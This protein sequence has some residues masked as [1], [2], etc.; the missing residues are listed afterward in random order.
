METCEDGNLDVTD[1]CD[2]VC[3]KSTCGDGVVWRGVEECDDSNSNDADRC[4]TDCS[5][6]YGTDFMLVSAP[7]E[8]SMLG[9]VDSTG[10]VPTIAFRST[11]PTLCRSGHVP[12][13]ASLPW[14]PCPPAD[15]MGIV[16]YKVESTPGRVDGGYSMQVSYTD[17]IGAY[18]VSSN[19]Y[20][21]RSIDGAVRCPDYPDTW[22]TDAQFFA[23]AVQPVDLSA[24]VDMPAWATTTGILE[25]EATLGTSDFQ[26]PV[27]A[28]K[29]TDS[30]FSSLVGYTTENL[31][32]RSFTPHM[33]PSKTKIA[34]SMPV[35]SLRHRIVNNPQ[36]TLI[37]VQRAYES[38]TNRRIDN[39]HQCAMKLDFGDYAQ[40]GAGNDFACDAL[41]MN[42]HGEGFCM[43]VTPDGTP[44]PI[45]FSRQL[46]AKIMSANVS[47]ISKA[48]DRSWSAKL[49]D[50]SY[51]YPDGMIETGAKEGEP[52]LILRP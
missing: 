30:W 47:A 41:V 50:L 51:F 38:R 46:V 44:Q 1:A 20:L 40:A 26:G 24:G 37:L 25:N 14:L 31:A 33:L 45:V 10:H 39:L 9:Y 42:A 19:F 18:T 43:T 4:H 48:G 12:E 22:P 7:V 49:L 23:A 28:L 21:H 8:G 3:M 17:T 35:F 2:N 15:E 29:F 11:T 16:S 52:L 6:N 34:F 13:V 32:N 36:N 5:I 27:Y